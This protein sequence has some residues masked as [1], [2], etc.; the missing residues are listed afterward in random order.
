MLLILTRFTGM[1]VGESN[2]SVLVLAVSFELS[3]NGVLVS[4]ALCVNQHFTPSELRTKPFAKCCAP[5][6]VAK[7]STA[8]TPA[9]PRYRDL[10]ELNI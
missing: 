9:N 7:D 5:A 2:T 1:H 8:K 3:L 10:G 4:S 6:A